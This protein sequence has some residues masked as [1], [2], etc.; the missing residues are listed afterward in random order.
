MEGMIYM[1]QVHHSFNILDKNAETQPER[2]A[3]QLANEYK[4]FLDQYQK[5]ESEEEREAANTATHR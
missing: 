2:R 5:A 1:R 4:F 3:T